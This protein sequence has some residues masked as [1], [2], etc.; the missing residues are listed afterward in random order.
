MNPHSFHACSIGDCLP[1]PAP[2]ALL[3]WNHPFCQQLGP[4]FPII[5]DTGAPYL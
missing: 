5:V 2:M 4:S 1:A 3:S